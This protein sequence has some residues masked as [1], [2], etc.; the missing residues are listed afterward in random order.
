MKTTSKSQPTPSPNPRSKTPVLAVL[1]L[2]LLLGAHSVKA[3]AAQW[4]W[5]PGGGSDAEGGSGIWNLAD[6]SW[7]DAAAGGGQHAWSNRG[8]AV[9]SGIGGAVELTEN[10]EAEGLRFESDGYLIEGPQEGAAL[11]LSGPAPEIAVADGVTA[12]LGRGVLL[13]RAAG[14]NFGFEKTGPGSLVLNPAGGQFFEATDPPNRGRIIR[15]R[16]GVLWVAGGALNNTRTILD[17]ADGA[18]LEVGA[19]LNIGWLRGDGLVTNSSADTRPLYL[20]GALADNPEHH[21]F[22]GAITGAIGL[23]KLNSQHTQILAGSEPNTFTG[24]LVINLGVVELAKEEGVVAAGGLVRLNA[25]SGGHAIAA[26]RL[27]GNGQFDE[28]TRLA[29]EGDGPGPNR[30]YLE[31]FSSALGELR[32]RGGSTNNAIDFGDNPDPQTLRFQRLDWDGGDAR[33]LV[34]NHAGGGG[35][36]LFT[37]DPSAGLAA[38]I[39]GERETGLAAEARYDDT[40]GAWEVYPGATAAEASGD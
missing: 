19:N 16:E 4:Y 24:G 2:F 21:T 40:A 10:I 6:T 30:L 8:V 31:G 37:E 36:L 1:G 33:L 17:I 13:E 7:A 15:V 20:R 22:R 28:N 3:D 14:G 34:L 11:T 23:V 12:N 5:N 29:F 26:V 18:T 38:I 32:L 9:F 25:G 35:Q 27:G 39:F